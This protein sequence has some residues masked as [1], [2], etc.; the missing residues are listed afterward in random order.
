MKVIYKIIPEKNLLMGPHNHMQVVT[1]SPAHLLK[2]LGNIMIG[3]Q[4][5]NESIIMIKFGEHEQNGWITV[6]QYKTVM[7]IAK[8]SIKIFEYRLHNEHFGRA[9]Q[10]IEIATLQEGS[11]CS[12]IKDGA[13]I[14]F[15]SIHDAFRNSFY[16]INDT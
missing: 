10:S 9:D 5:N 15:P 4:E 3:Q 8:H 1:T 6:E 2:I 16:A 12:I 7:N 11:I 13:A 14:I